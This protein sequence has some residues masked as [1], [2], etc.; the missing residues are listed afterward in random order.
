[1]ANLLWFF[2]DPLRWFVPALGADTP[3]WSPW[4]LYA[5][6]WAIVVWGAARS[7]RRR[8]PTPQDALLRFVSVAFPLQVA[9]L[10]LLNRDLHHLAQATPTLAIL[11]ALALESAAASF[12][13]PRTPRRVALVAAGAA[14]WLAAGV[15]SLASTDS[16]LATVQAPIVTRA[17]QVELVHLL[18]QAGVRRVWTSEYDVYGVLEVL[19]PDLEVRHAWG[20]VSRSGDRNALLAQLLAKA[21]GPG[22]DPGCYVALRPA[23]RRIY[24]LFPSDE[25]VH[26]AA[27]VAGVQV[28]RAAAASDPDGDW[29]V[30]WRVTS[31]GAA[32]EGA[33]GP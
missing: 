8:D 3:G 9:F 12:S 13:P 2:A 28:V 5:V 31:P 32:S 21:A 15:T 17:G 27:A 33:A 6:G 22:S 23:A 20:A 25:T 30:L 19:A 16:V 18:R 10:F 11:G 7:W 14:A 29:A 4:P 26:R 1:V 24:D